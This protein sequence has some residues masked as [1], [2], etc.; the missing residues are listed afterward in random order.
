MARDIA[1]WACTVLAY[2]HATEV[3]GI[4]TSALIEAMGRGAVVLYR[5]TP[6]ECRESRAM[7]AFPLNRK[8]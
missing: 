1:N 7:R 5:N 3:G 2:I 4:C 6:G 8:S